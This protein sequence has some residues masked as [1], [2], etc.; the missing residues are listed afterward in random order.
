[1]RAPSGRAA[2]FVSCPRCEQT[3][4]FAVDGDGTALSADEVGGPA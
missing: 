3:A 1:M 2:V 4:W